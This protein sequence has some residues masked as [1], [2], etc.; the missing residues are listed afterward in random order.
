MAHNQRPPRRRTHTQHNTGHI[1]P[2]VCIHRARHPPTHLSPCACCIG[3][4]DAKN[5]AS[6]CCCVCDMATVVLEYQTRVWFANAAQCSHAPVASVR[7]PTPKVSRLVGHGNCNCSAHG[8]SRE[9][10]SDTRKFIQ[11]GAP[12]LNK[13]NCDPANPARGNPRPHEYVLRQPRRSHRPHAAVCELVLGVVRARACVRAGSRRMPR[14]CATT[15]A[16]PCPRSRIVQF[17]AGV[18]DAAASPFRARHQLLPPTV[19]RTR[20][21]VGAPSRECASLTHHGELAPR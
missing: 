15:C 6:C 1:G 12:R 2:G 5:A 14:V 8:E 10:R 16:T 20:V 7:C 9:A 17:C 11:L 18:S 21:A 13:F 3:V 19:P 4:A